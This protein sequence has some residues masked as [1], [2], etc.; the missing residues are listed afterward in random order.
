MTSPYKVKHWSPVKRIP[1]SVDGWYN[2]L[3][4]ED[5]DADEYK[6]PGSESSSDFFLKFFIFFLLCECGNVKEQISNPSTCEWCGTTPTN[7]KQ[8][9]Q[10]TTNILQL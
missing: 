2:V 3:E 6:N 7:N 10:T 8:H 1:K 9:Y 4:W 5:V